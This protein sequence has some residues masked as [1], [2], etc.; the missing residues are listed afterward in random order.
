VIVNELSKATFTARPISEDGTE[1]T[2]TNARYRLDDKAATTE[3]IA[4][5]ALTPSTA[6]EILIPAPTHAMVNANL[7]LETKVLTIETDFGTDNAH[8]AEFE[9]QIQNMQFVS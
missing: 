4:W 2:P 1:F 8:V 5:T 9:Y 3:L 7:N 6:M